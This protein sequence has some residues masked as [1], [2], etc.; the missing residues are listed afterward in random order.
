MYILWSGWIECWRR[1]QFWN[2]SRFWNRKY[3]TLVKQHADLQNGCPKQPIWMHWRFHRYSNYDLE[4]LPVILFLKLWYFD[5]KIT[6]FFEQKYFYITFLTNIIV[7]WLGELRAA[8]RFG[9]FLG[10]KK[11]SISGPCYAE[12]D[13]IQCKFGEFVVDGRVIDSRTAECISPFMGSTGTFSL[14]MSLNG[15][16]DFRF[17]GQFLYGKTKK[18]YYS[19]IEDLFLWALVNWWNLWNADQT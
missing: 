13:V 8:P 2:S 15:G 10:G 12:T 16:Q 7:F 6:N 5:Q 17:H 4:S 14:T 19:F 18:V 11:I 3:P 9:H 1:Y